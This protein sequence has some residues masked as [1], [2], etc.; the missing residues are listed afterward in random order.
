M[1]HGRENLIYDIIHLRREGDIP[2]GFI[3][4][5]SVGTV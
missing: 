3:T 4:G 5:G 1:L 2:F